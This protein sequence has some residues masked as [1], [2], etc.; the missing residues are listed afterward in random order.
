MEELNSK[1][2]ECQSLL[3]EN[4]A[5]EIADQCCEYF[6][7]HS[8]KLLSQTKEEVQ[9]FFSELQNRK[10][11]NICLGTVC[12]IS[13]VAATVAGTLTQQYWLNGLT[14]SFVA[15]GVKKI[16]KGNDSTFISL[17]NLS[18]FPNSHID[19]EKY[20]NGTI[21]V[22]LNPCFGKVIYPLQVEI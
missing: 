20:G 7:N 18:F 6:E 21:A 1:R 10:I 14:N 15:Y 22:T 11:F 4:V 16:I 3:K 12:V 2:M 19:L 9:N 8:N 17:K 13:G 5:K